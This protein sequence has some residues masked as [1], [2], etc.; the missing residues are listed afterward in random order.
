LSYQSNAEGQAT[1]AGTAVSAGNLDISNY[2][3]V[4]QSDPIATA[5]N[6]TPSSIG[7][8]GTNGRGTATIVTTNPPATYTLIY[9]VVDSKTAV[10]VGQDKTRVATGAIALQF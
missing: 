4:Y 9:Y 2:G 5:V 6:T 8:P 10:L 3:A 7:A 1:L